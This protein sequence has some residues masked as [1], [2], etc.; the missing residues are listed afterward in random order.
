MFLVVAAAA[1]ALPSAALALPHSPA[2][3]SRITGGQV[4]TKAWP[5]TGALDTRR[6]KADC[7]GVLVSGRWFLTAAHCVGDP[8]VDPHD[9]FVVTLGRSDL[10]QATD[11]DRY[12][13]DR[14]VD[15]HARYDRDDLS[16][17]LALLHLARA[18]PQD[19]LRLVSP[20]E[21]ALWKPGTSATLVGWGLTC[22]R[23]DS[24][25]QL[26]QVTIPIIDDD[27]CRSLEP[28]GFKPEV[29]VCAGE[30]HKGGCDGDSGGPLMVER[31]GEPVLVG[32]V[33]GGT[34]QCNLPEHPGFFTR[35]GAPALNQWVRE[36]IP[37]VALSASPSAPQA[38]DTVELL[39]AA[40]APPTQAASP[41]Y[42]WDLDGDGA[43][44]D[45]AG[46][47]L[48]ISSVRQGTYPV[49]V[50]AVYPDGDRAV[51][52]EVVTVAAAGTVAAV[53]PPQLVGAPRRIRIRSLRDRRISFRVRCFSACS[54]RAT[55]RLTGRTRGA[56]GTT[57][58]KLGSGQARTAQ[59]A[60]VRVTVKL[61]RSGLRRL[62]RV[63]R[64]SLELR[65]TVTEAGRSTPLDHRV[66][67]TR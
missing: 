56:R 35:L 36:R 18:A 46:P 1:L 26:R 22:S 31:L 3:K 61:T 49:R 43:F 12:A 48:R 58:T 27:T 20:G 4:A 62:R 64:G 60:T 13:V 14:P 54:V 51:T 37:T 11:A 65:A 21:P 2:Y 23:C 28:R 42:S 50:Q 10:D 29:M 47:V 19:P 41:S 32:T 53:A 44:D 34:H 7:G 6:A 52:R 63:R 17:D 33:S 59:A 25:R 55:L 38:G 67:L 24:V 57:R 15:R 30:G 66:A 16:Y 9:Q 39:A 40:T 8:T 5:A 45:G